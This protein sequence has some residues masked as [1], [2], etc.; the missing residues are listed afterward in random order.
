MSITRAVLISIAIALLSVVASIYVCLCPRFNPKLVNFILFH[1]IKAAEL[2]DTVKEIGGC[3][4][5][6]FRIPVGGSKQRTMDA[7]FYEKAGAPD[8]VLYNH[9]N[10]GNISH[11]LLNIEGLLASGRSVF[12]YDYE[13]YGKS[14]GAPSVDGVIDDATAACD[15][16]VNELQYSPEQI[17]FYGESLGTAITG[18]LAGKRKCQGV[19]LDAAF[20]SVEK[21]GKEKIA[22]ANVFPSFL[23]VQ[24][25]LDNLAFV[26]QK[27]PP[28]LFIAGKNDHMVPISHA[29]FLFKNAMQPKEFAVMPNSGHVLEAP[30]LEVY[31]QTL[32][33]FFATLDSTSSK[34]PAPTS[35]ANETPVGP[36]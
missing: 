36:I 35:G 10:G 4:G 27:H 15:Y 7:W 13:G 31:S 9:G 11:R 32:S 29:R 5:Q 33:R 34:P 1:P 25:P 24:P 14:D 30:D 17:V 23:F 28:L 22:F 20:I 26:S 12:I 3:K 16:L 8:V 2:P 18:H 19:V 21:L 6:E